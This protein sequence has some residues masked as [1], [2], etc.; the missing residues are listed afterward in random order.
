[1]LEGRVQ[2]LFVKLANCC[3]RASAINLWMIVVSRQHDSATFAAP[4]AKLM[5]EIGTKQTT[6][7][8]PPL[9]LHGHDRFQLCDHSR[10]SGIANRV[11]H[12]ADAF[13]RKRSLLS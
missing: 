5:A 10:N 11:D 6:C 13:V 4:L 9:S 8:V 12:R 3:V 1:M 7:F 2:A